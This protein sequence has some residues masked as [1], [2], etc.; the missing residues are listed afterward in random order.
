MYL[1]YSIQQIQHYIEFCTTW[2]H[3]SGKGECFNFYLTIIEINRFVLFYVM[4]AFTVAEIKF[5]L[6]TH[7]FPS[8][9]IFFI[10]G[11]YYYSLL[12]IQIAK[13]VKP[14]NIVIIYFLSCFS[15]MYEL[16]KEEFCRQ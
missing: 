5:I 9:F 7:K 1:R 11:H 8:A 10:K 12:L 4:I 2:L 14:V 3:T 16:L 13:K 15:C 6:R